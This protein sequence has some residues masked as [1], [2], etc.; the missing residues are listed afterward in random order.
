[1]KLC[2]TE[3]REKVSTNENSERTHAHKTAIAHR[4]LT[5]SATEISWWL[6]HGVDFLI[7]S[8]QLPFYSSAKPCGG[9]PNFIDVEDKILMGMGRPRGDFLSH[10]IVDAEL[11][12]RQFDRV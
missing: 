6:G 1:M 11:P 5:F 10:R 7:T 12:I 2:D 9:A 3:F 4:V 8:R